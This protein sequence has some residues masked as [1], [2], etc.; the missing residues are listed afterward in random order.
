MKD[1]IENLEKI[2][3]R[4][5]HIEPQAIYIKDEITGD[6]ILHCDVEAFISNP[7]S[8]ES[9]DLEEWA[10]RALVELRK[11]ED[12]DFNPSNE[13]TT[14]DEIYFTE[15]KSYAKDQISDQVKDW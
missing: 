3:L 14:R 10:M 4:I 5:V 2:S 6:H 1:I 11:A 13:L 8:L 15:I 9:P 12:V 7:E